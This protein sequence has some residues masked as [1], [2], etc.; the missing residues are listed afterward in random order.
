MQIWSTLFGLTSAP[1][2]LTRF[3]IEISRSALSLGEHLT[4]W[5]IS[6]VPRALRV[7]LDVAADLVGTVVASF[8]AATPHEGVH[9]ATIAGARSDG[10]DDPP[11]CDRNFRARQAPLYV[12]DAGSGPAIVLL[13]AFPLSSRMWEPQLRSLSAR[14]RVVAP[15]L[16]G[17]GLSWSRATALSLDEQAHAVEL[18]LDDLGIDE[19]V[20]VGASMGGSVALPLLKR[21]GSRVRGLVL[22]NTRATADDERTVDERHRL[23]A[24]VEADGVDVAADELLPKLLG[25]STARD[26]PELVDHVH[27]LVLENKEPGVIGALR[28]MAA[29]PDA[30][31]MLASIAC[32]TL[33]IAG[34]EDTLV[35]VAAARALAAAI[36]DAQVAVL[37]S[38]HL[39]NLEASLDFDRVLGT[40]ARRAHD[41]ARRT[42]RTRRAHG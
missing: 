18:T 15:D 24:E 41:A 37:H 30:T 4:P 29:R 14:F 2:R 3:G 25:A 35:P 9:T 6:L 8:D 26:L 38:G 13:H 23:A 31:P 20:L 11:R 34:D 32:P 5:P 10:P 42:P 12:R 27:A 36:P 39:P 40:F 28:A 1:I 22:A 19:L 7:P 17:F 21:L 16:A 33:V